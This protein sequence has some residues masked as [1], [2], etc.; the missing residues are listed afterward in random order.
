VA[1]PLRVSPTIT[2]TLPDL[3]EQSHP[4]L[5]HHRE[6]AGG[7][8]G[9]YRGISRSANGITYSRCFISLPPTLTSSSAPSGK[10]GWQGCDNAK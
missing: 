3:S 9:G 10:E 8:F 5:T 2:L 4:S 1:S 7:C 6:A